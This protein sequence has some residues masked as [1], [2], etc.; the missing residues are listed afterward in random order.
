MPRGSGRTKDLTGL[1]FNRLTVIELAYVKRGAI[2]RCRCVCG[3]ETL[4]ATER[5]RN[6][7][8]K[9][10]GCSR[11]RRDLVGKIYGRLEVIELARLSGAHK[12]Y[13]CRCNCGAVV[14][15]FQTNLLRGLS[16]SCGCYRSDWTRE[17]KTTHGMSGTAVYA[18]LHGLKRRARIEITENSDVTPDAMAEML[19]AQNY[20][21][22]WCD[23][24]FG[25][26]APHQDHV[27][28]ISRGGLHMLD[29][30]VWACASC[31]TQKQ[32]QLPHDWFLKPSCRA[33]KFKMV[34]ERSDK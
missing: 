5:L 34:P 7:S 20:Q 33:R 25:D 11:Q 10:C 32:A 30:L 16:R 27:I 12:V 29:N 2:W 1:V 18:A 4:T 23:E 6:G 26:K 17:N 15:A 22:Y 24:F 14:E 28:P 31:N 19:L 8:V 13:R 21:C 3:N 9:S